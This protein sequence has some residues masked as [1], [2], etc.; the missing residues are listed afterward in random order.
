M[1]RNNLRVGVRRTRTD[2]FQWCPA[3]GQGATGTKLRHRKFYLNT[4]KIFFP[5]RVTEPWNRLSRDVVDSSSL[6]IFKTRLEEV[7]CNL[8]QVTL[9]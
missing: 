5:L 3:T 4:R 8:L 7:L 2:S 9:L 6:E 1:L